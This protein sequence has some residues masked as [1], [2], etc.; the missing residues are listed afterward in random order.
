MLNC[1]TTY[2]TL[3]MRRSSLIILFCMLLVSFYAQDSTVTRKD[4]PSVF[5]DCE[6]CASNF[7]KQEITYVNFVRD[8]RLADIY[9]LGT[10][11]FNGGG[12]VQM[13]LYFVGEGRFKGQNDTLIC[14]LP[15]NTSDGDAREALLKTV[16]QG[17]LKYLVQTNLLEKVNYSIDMGEE[18]LATDSV[19]D[20]WN[21]WL[22]NINSNVDGSASSYQSELN[23]NAN[24][25]ANRTTKK[26][27]TE[28]GG[29]YSLNKQK[30]VIDDTTTVTGLQS[31]MGG[32]HLL[33]VTVGEHWA[34]GQF[35][36]YFRSTQNNLRNSYSY[37]PGIEYNVFD[38]EEAGRRQLRFI[39]RAGLR[40]QDY[41]ETTIYDRK[42]EFYGLHSFVVQWSQIEKWGNL[43]LTAGAWHYFNY[44]SNYSAS[45]YP[46]IN[47][48]PLKGLR[49]G[50]WC[51][52]SMVNDQ[53]FLRKSEATANEILLE[54]VNLKTDFNYNYGFNINYT[55]GSKYNNFINVRF[56]LDDNYW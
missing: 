4:L 21:F 22:F 40:Y 50:L 32:Y 5:M 23:V 44:P 45:I 42:S 36:T 19:K 46:S 35:A 39:Y 16:K 48:N 51:G 6:F 3:F 30:F 37:Y 49:V 9:M 17:F 41:F 1:I 13:T 53:F 54:Q 33:A 56:N 47:F 20:K 15:P 12:S 7:F 55:F 18:E 43:N 10:V 31:N 28:T 52:F 38:Y 27:K 26:L 14:K 8:R 24:I 25:N 2:Q 34:V 11:N 29:W